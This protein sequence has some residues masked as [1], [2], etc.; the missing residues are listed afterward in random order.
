MASGL[1]GG[2]RVPLPPGHYRVEVLT[3]PVIVLEDVVIDAGTSKDIQLEPTCSRT[4][5]CSLRR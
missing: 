3:D 5:T 2:D 1:V 4:L